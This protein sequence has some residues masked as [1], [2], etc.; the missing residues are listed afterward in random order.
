MRLVQ[1]GSGFS[2]V[3][4]AALFISAACAAWAS[5][6]RIVVAQ[7][8]AENFYDFEDDPATTGDD[9]YIPAGWTRWTEYR[10]RLKL[11]NIAE[12]VSHM[13][14]D[15]LCLEEIENKRVLED[16]QEVLENVFKWPMKYSVHRDSTDP[17][18]LDCTMLSRLLS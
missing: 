12:V 6:D 17:R 1:A 8:N 10:Y 3:A 13:K 9:A 18:G 14:P 4:L 7:W 16:L 11:T 5:A 2:K 15:I